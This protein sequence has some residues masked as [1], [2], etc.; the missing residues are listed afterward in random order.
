[1]PA[2]TVLAPASAC[3]FNLSRVNRHDFNAEPMKEEIEFAACHY[4]APSFEYNSGLQSIWS[5]NQARSILL[6]KLEETPSLRFSKKY[7][8]ESG[9]ID[10]HQRGS[11]SAS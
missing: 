11:P 10:H 7:G 1:M 3:N 6:N 4:P 2:F 5:G 8:K 9:S